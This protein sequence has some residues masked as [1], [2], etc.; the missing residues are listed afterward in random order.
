MRTF[1]Q[2]VKYA[3]RNLGRARGFA[4]L[5]I[6][7]LALGI[8]ANTAI[9]S[10]VNAIVLR[11]LSYPDSPEL[12]RI[13]SALRALDADDTGVA[14][15]ELF[16]YQALSD[17]F[18]GVAG[19]YPVNANVTGGDEPERVEVMLVSPN[20]FSILKAQP[21]SGRVFGPDDNG[22]GI[23]EVV[24]VSDGYWRRR[25]G[26]D[27]NALGKTLMVDGDPFVLVGVMP[28][29]FRHPGRTQ[30][31]DV[32]MWSPA[33]FRA[34]PFGEPNRNRRFLEG[35]LARLK[36][37]V[38]LDQAQLRLDAYG[39]DVRQRFPSDYPDRT[40]WTPRL[41]SVQSDVVGSVETPMLILLSAVG[42]VLLI[43]CANVAHLVLVRAAERQ[44][45]MAIR[46]ALGASAGRLTRQLLTESALLATAGSLLGLLMASWGMQALIAIAPSR[47]PRL[48]EVTM[49]WSAVGVTAVLGGITALIFGLVPAWQTRRLNTFGLVKEGGQGR[50]A[51]SRGAKARNVLVSAEVALAMVLLVGAGLLIRSVG[52]LLDVPLGFKS[53][54]LLTSRIWLPRPNDSAK[55]IYLTPEK[56]VAFYRETLTRVGALPGVE[57]A[58]MSTQVPM[59]GW[60]PPV[61]YEVEGRDLVDQKVRPV[62]QQFQVSPNYFEAL[63]I[64]VV[65]GRAFTD[66]DRA[67]AEPVIMISE[68]AARSIWAEENP[69]GKRVR[70][71]PQ[72]PW[73]TVVG[74][75]G[76][77]RNRRLDETPPPIL[78]RSLDQSSGLELALLVRTRG[79]TPGLAEA[80]AR[81]VRAVDPALPLYAVRTMDDLLSGA[82]AQRRFLMRILA[83]FG[84]AAVGLALLGIYGVISYS[85]SQRT[86]E[87]GI[88]IAIGAQHSDVSRMVVRQGLALTAVGAVAGLAGALALS[89]L[90]KSQLF[91]VQ[92]SD[93]LTLVTVVIVMGLVA[94]AAAWLPARRAARVDPI[95]ALRRE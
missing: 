76:D 21:Q 70:F 86:R 61:F 94:T 45:E 54:N 66:L 68:S 91:G 53:D 85:V 15:Q 79:Q 58:A 83:A 2:D 7:T 5:V 64:P 19:L 59:G 40:G 90:I 39:A 56:R 29:D 57:H 17:V 88:R 43:V 42:L 55:G 82:V 9:F 16:D 60:R 46:Q 92:P 72:T 95:I 38:T 74:V 62:I 50:S 35:A 6:L 28:P 37:G 65:R 36:P 67:E 89:Q 84:A 44:Q 8:G 87:I 51:S 23:P 48:A 49:D 10:I 63:E 77:V 93:P 14:A 27:P 32:D 1:V 41:V 12:V 4:A 34:M 22:P 20:Y 69:I 81:E 11:P 31:T 52:E 18:T 24:I 33:G 30:Q 13:T 80:I 75:A 47:V 78:Y 25:L 3:I 71:N 73:M 26:A